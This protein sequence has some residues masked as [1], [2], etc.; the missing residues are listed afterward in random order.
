M[1]LHQQSLVSIERSR[2][3]RSTARRPAIPADPE[4][5]RTQTTRRI[6]H[7]S[8]AEK[9]AG[10]VHLKRKEEG[11]AASSAELWPWWRAAFYGGKL[12]SRARPLEARGRRGQFNP[13][14]A[15][16]H[17]L[18]GR[19][20]GF[21]AMAGTAATRSAWLHASALHRRPRPPRPAPFRSPGSPRS[22]APATSTSRSSIAP[23]RPTHPL[24]D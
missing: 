11:G 20:P 9:L 14:L 21:R 18:D 23:R 3:R 4:A 13:K 24:V 16:Q 15:V 7:T 1:R 19:A 17:Q 6:R 10:G 22:T 5:P 2:T 8:R 12:V